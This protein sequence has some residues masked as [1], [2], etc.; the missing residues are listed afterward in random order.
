[1]RASGA[2]FPKELGHVPARNI[3]Q[4]R[5][6]AF[7]DPAVGPP[8]P[9]TDRSPAADG[10]QQFVERGIGITVIAAKRHDMLVHEPAYAPLKIERRLELARHAVGPDLRTP[11]AETG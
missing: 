10:R 7:A 1:M 5:H 6:L 3:A 9:R 11:G 2:L 8:E 4:S